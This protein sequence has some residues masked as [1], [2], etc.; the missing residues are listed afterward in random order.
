MDQ[1][2]SPDRPLRGPRVCWAKVRELMMERSRYLIVG[3]GMTA[4]AAARG[5][6]DVDETDTILLVGAEPDSPYKRPLLSKGLWAGKP[7]DRVWSGT[8]RYGV[9]LRLGRTI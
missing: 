9:D 1:T 4:A 3:G 8:E 5:I 2:Q 6:R 7:L